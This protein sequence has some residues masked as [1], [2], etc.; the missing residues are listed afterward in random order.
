M[1]G[2]DPWGIAS[3]ATNG[4]PVFKRRKENEGGS[5]VVTRLAQRSTECKIVFAVMHIEPIQNDKRLNEVG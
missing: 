4:F 1:I 5:A 2:R 3:C